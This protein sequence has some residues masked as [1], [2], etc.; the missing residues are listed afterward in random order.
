M[1]P[2]FQ[3]AKTKRQMKHALNGV[4]ERFHTVERRRTEFVFY[5]VIRITQ[6]I[7]YAARQETLLCK[8]YTDVF[9]LFY[10]H[11]SIINKI[12]YVSLY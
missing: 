6:D 5:H 12:V 1:A 9:I 11:V 4:D 2:H 8:N 7:I 10:F 3:T